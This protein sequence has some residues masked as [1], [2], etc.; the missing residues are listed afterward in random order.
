[1]GSSCIREGKE[2][3]EQHKKPERSHSV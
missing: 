2:K 3:K 1:L